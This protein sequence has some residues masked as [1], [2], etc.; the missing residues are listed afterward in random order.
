M[1]DYILML[2]SKLPIFNV[3]CQKYLNIQK[4]RVS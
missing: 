1:L 3:Y 4:S 2:I